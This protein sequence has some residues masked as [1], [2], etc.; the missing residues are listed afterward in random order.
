MIGRVGRLG[1][2]EVLLGEM[3]DTREPACHSTIPSRAIC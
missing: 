1:V 2:G 3:L